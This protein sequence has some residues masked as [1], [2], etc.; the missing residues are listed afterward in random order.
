MT[1]KEHYERRV[2]ESHLCQHFKKNLM[3]KFEKIFSFSI[4]WQP[5]NFVI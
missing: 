1:N 3:L 2:S 5:M 4:G